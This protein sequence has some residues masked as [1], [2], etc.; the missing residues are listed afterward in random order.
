MAKKFLQSQIGDNQFV[1]T[2]EETK[3]I[4]YVMVRLVDAKGKVLDCDGPWPRGDCRLKHREMEVR[5]GG[6]ASSIL[7]WLPA[8]KTGINKGSKK[9]ARVATPPSIVNHIESMGLYDKIG[10]LTTR[11][12]LAKVFGK[13]KSSII[14]A[15]P[16]TK[17]PATMAYRTILVMTEKI[18]EHV[19]KIT[20]GKAKVLS[21]SIEA[22][23]V[24]WEQMFPQYP[25]L[26][27]SDFERGDYFRQAEIGMAVARF[28][29]RIKDGSSC[30]GSLLRPKDE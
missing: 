5:H 14:A 28:G 11:A 30:V 16:L 19:E 23:F 15:G 29:Q 6:T 3:D 8:P 18:T 25:D 21:T 10:P 7:E 24:V 13:Q 9:A 26:S 1:I 2:G 27:E 17:Q 22:K 4:R 20:H 12:N